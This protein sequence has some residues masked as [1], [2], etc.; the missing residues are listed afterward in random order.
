MIHQLA[1]DDTAQD[2]ILVLR[3]NTIFRVTPYRNP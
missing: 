1:G 2:E 3:P